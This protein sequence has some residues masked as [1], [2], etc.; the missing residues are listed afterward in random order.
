MYLLMIVCIYIYIYRYSE[1]TNEA[2]VYVQNNEYD[3]TM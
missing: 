1:K 2:I 3:Y